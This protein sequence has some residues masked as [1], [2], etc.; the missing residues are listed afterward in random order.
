MSLKSKNLHEFISLFHTSN[1]CNPP[2][3]YTIL[4]KVLR[5]ISQKYDSRI[6]FLDKNV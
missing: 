1:L 2:K 4:M 6:Y 5:L 3:T